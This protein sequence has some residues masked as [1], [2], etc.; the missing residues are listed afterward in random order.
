MKKERSFVVLTSTG[1]ESF[2][3]KTLLF[4]GN[5][6]TIKD[7][8]EAQLKSIQEELEREKERIDELGEVNEKLKHKL[9]EE[10]GGEQEKSGDQR[11][12]EAIIAA[13]ERDREIKKLKQEL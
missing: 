9:K 3:K 12:K 1:K 6:Y 8:L 4:S 13:G 11:E 7:E 2:I 5:E 10:N